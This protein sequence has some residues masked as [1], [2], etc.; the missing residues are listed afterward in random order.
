[1]NPE[2]INER[3]GDL[4]NAAPDKL[5]QE[6]R[7]LMHDLGAELPH[8]RIGV[9]RKLQ[10]EIHHQTSDK[11]KKIDPASFIRGALYAAY[12]TCDGYASEVTP[13][14]EEAARRLER[15][16]LE[17]LLVPGEGI[18]VLKK[19]Q[20]GIKIDVP[21]NK[22]SVRLSRSQTADFNKVAAALIT[23]DNHLPKDCINASSEIGSTIMAVFAGPEA[24]QEFAGTLAN[25]GVNF[26]GS[27]A[28][29]YIVR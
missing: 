4:L 26:P 19:Y 28:Y 23:T 16:T 13:V 3:L 24:V 17:N 25:A 27:E 29:R 1:M 21:G 15:E 9:L 6:V 2:T 8:N 7:Y 18:D 22:V 10:A 11:P 20:E 12:H 5:E 14:L